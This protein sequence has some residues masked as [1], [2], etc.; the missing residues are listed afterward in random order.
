MDFK[1]HFLS[2]EREKEKLKVLTNTDD[3]KIDV[4]E[5]LV[6]TSYLPLR[7][8]RSLRRIICIVFTCT[9][10]QSLENDKYIFFFE[11]KILYKPLRSPASFIRFNRS[12]IYF[13]FL[14][15]FTLHSLQAQREDLK[16]LLNFMF[17]FHL[18][19]LSLS[20]DELGS[21]NF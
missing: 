17:C 7:P 13:L 5:I 2:N 21:F 3:L 18:I 14:I 8:C 12:Y 19:K 6:I 1:R 9:C 20:I 11:V 4:W 15:F 10:I 16:L